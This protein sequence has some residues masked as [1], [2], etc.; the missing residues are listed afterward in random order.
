MRE[1]IKKII[2]IAK[3]TRLPCK[4]YC[5]VQLICEIA[6]DPTATWKLFN[7][8]VFAAWRQS[9]A[10]KASQASSPFGKQDACIN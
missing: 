8:K 7:V 5:F 9:H 1:S 4:P 3:Q 2:W 6:V 10:Y